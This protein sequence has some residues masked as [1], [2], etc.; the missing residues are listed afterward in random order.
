MRI[1]TQGMDHRSGRGLQARE[2][3]QELVVARH[4]LSEL[5]GQCVEEADCPFGAYDRRVLAQLRSHG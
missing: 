2:E 3:E 5:L 4:E 1:G